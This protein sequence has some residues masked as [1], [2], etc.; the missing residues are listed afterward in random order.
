MPVAL[1][2]RDCDAVNA[3]VRVARQPPVGFRLAGLVVDEVA[4][5][6]EWRCGCPTGATTGP[7]RLI[8]EDLHAL[9]PPRSARSSAAPPLWCLS[10][11]EL[12]ERPDAQARIV[13]TCG[14]PSGI[15][16]TCEPGAAITRWALVERGRSAA[17]L[18]ELVR[19][20]RG[21]MAR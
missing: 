2:L 20:R 13:E 15:G 19:V 18:Y 7:C 3:E 1:T 10:G 21:L 17:P 12:I 16:S 4:T 8:E 6:P 11:A 9:F 5:A 14:A